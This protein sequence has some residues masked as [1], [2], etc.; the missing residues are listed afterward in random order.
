MR[1]L[2]SNFWVLW[3]PPIGIVTPYFGGLVPYVS[4]R[5]SR[6]SWTLLSPKSLSKNGTRRKIRQ[7]KRKVANITQIPRPT[8]ATLRTP[9]SPGVAWRD[10]SLSWERHLYSVN[11]SDPLLV[12]LHSAVECLCCGVSTVCPLDH[13]RSGVNS[14]GST[15]CPFRHRPRTHTLL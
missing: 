7:A 5:P 13:V 8:R 11:K 9:T 4:A 12:S 1:V 2:A 3:Q 15:V 10:G 6:T 14:S